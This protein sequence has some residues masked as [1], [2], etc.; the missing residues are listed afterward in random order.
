MSPGWLGPAVLG[1]A[2][3]LAGR[4]HLGAELRRKSRGL[5]DFLD[6]VGSSTTRP[7]KMAPTTE[8]TI[9]P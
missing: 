9:E 6:A 3:L 8:P 2:K 7:M 4:Q 1:F 5:D